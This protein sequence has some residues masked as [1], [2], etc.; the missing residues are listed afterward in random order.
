MDPNKL[1]FSSKSVAG[2]QQNPSKYFST[3][4]KGK[5]GHTGDLE[6][7]KADL[8]TQYQ[9]VQAAKILGIR[10]LDHIIVSRKGYL[11]FQEAGINESHPQAGDL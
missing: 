9:L 10:V 4:S 1:Q 6:P 11:S 3:K 8:T 5:G 7:S 2:Q